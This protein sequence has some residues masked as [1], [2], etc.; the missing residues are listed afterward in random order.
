M[1]LT[2]SGSSTP[3]ASDSGRLRATYR[4]HTP[5]LTPQARMVCQ[6]AW[7]VVADGLARLEQLTRFNVADIQA[8]FGCI[9]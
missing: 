2:Y 5:Q 3:D 8:P 6:R 4:F 9:L 1:P 7:Q